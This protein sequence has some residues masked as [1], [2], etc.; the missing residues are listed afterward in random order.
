[1][2]EQE[3]AE[4][5]RKMLYKGSYD[6]TTTVVLFA[7]E[8]AA[9]LEAHVPNKTEFTERAV[10]KNFGPMIN[11]GINLSRHVKLRKLS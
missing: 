2:D 1:M 6:R 5:L 11:L 4:K 7:I 8:H 9:F 3:A 10:G